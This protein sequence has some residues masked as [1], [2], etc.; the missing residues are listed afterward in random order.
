MALAACSGASVDKDGF[1]QEE[2]DMVSSKSD[3]DSGP[4]AP[5]MIPADCESLLNQSRAW[6]YVP[7]QKW[8][9]AGPEQAMEAAKFFTEFRMVPIATSNALREIEM[10]QKSSA[11]AQP[12]DP[13]LAQNFLE[14]LVVYP[15]GKAARLE[16]GQNLHRFLLNQQSLHLPLVHRLVVGRVFVGAVRAGLVRGS[17]ADAK[18]FQ[19][20]MEKQAQS[21]PPVGEGA[22]DELKRQRKELKVSG[23]IR[24][25]MGMLLPLP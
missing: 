21:L 25:R 20:W 22:S 13:F 23:Q 8:K 10:G 16:A 5:G 19:A 1:S 6:S 7:G 12:C 18:G 9:P 17:H 2:I 3:V 15:W 11:E 14:A 4:S 24:D